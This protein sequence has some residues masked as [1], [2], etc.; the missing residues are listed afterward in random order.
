MPQAGDKYRIPKEASRK[1]AGAGG[2]APPFPKKKSRATLSSA[3]ATRPIAMVAVHEMSTEQ[4]AQWLST[5]MLALWGRATA[6]RCAALFRENDVSGDVLAAMSREDRCGS[7]ARALLCE[8]FALSAAE[9]QVLMASVN[10]D[11]HASATATVERMGAGTEVLIEGLRSKPSPSP[12]P[13]P[14]ALAL[15]CA[16]ARRG[17]C[18][19][20]TRARR[21]RGAG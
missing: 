4:V 18:L 20:L 1:G 19:F 6:E 17:F 8:E 5:Q 16:R 12:S 14:L 2:G 21:S 9:C 7:E 13:S 10:A 3:A 15:A 11:G